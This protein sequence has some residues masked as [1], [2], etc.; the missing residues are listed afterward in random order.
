LKRDNSIVA[1]KGAARVNWIDVAWTM[2]ASASLTLGLV[3]LA[4]WLKQREQYAYLLFFVLAASVAPFSM[5]ELLAV[6]AQTPA[7][8]W[9]AVRVVQIPVVILVLSIIAFI[10]YYFGVGRLW[11]AYAGGGLRILATVVT[12]ASGT[13]PQFEQVTGLDHAVWW[14]ATFSTPISTPSP[15]LPV[16]HLS[17]LLVI[18][19]VIDASITLWRR[20]DEIS[21]RRAWLVGGALT[22]CMVAAPVLVAFVI[23]GVLKAPTLFSPCFLVVVI[24]MGYELGWDVIYAGR[25]DAKLRSSEERFRSVVESVPNVILVI[26]DSGVITFA[27]ANAKTVFGYERDEIIGR[28]VEMLLPERLRSSHVALRAGYARD[29]EARPMG[30]GRELFAQR[31]DGALVP[32]EVGLSPMRTGDKLFVLV[33]LVDVTQRRRFEQVNA[34]QRSELAHLSRAAMLGELS[35]SLAHEL[36]Q[37]LT[38][39]LSNAQAAQRLL[40]RSPPDLAMLSDILS[41][42]VKNDHRAGAVIQ[43]LRSMLRKEE[44]ERQPLVVNDVVTDSLLLMR[45]DLISR[46]V[47][48]NT[49]L[50]PGLPKVRGDRVQLQQVLLNFVINSCDAM[51]GQPADRQLLVSTRAG[52]NGSIEVAVADR[53]TGISPGDIERIFEPF[54]TTK[55]RGMG[56]GL[57]ICR[58]IVEAHGG[59]VWASNNADRGATLHLELPVDG[60]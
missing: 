40:A 29:P 15:W 6:R 12:L 27:N 58:T 48:A 30:V 7:D 13:T 26:D 60:H 4:V 44:T 16:A 21:R 59:R 50:A 57:A 55:P 38:A 52:G 31:K 42:I 1:A 23:L 18:A 5:L 51:D 28:R 56:L 3:Y 22:I 2:M 17:N 46:E 25:L 14:G 37:P 35:G 39:I 10:R 8:Y 34:E 53:G 41:D 9:F 43:R 54:M 49:D 19:F 36:N 45:S 32:V 20:G 11:L 24:A 47:S 33:S